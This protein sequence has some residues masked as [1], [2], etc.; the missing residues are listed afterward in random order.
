MRWLARPGSSRL[1]SV[2]LLVGC[3]AVAAASLLLDRALSYDAW[4]WLMWGREL[5]GHL[6]FSTN[7][8]PTWKPLTGLLAVPL[9][10]LGG[11]GPAL[12]LLIARFGAVLSLALAFRLGRR[13][14]GPGAGVLAAA[15]VLLMPDWVFQAGV[16]GSEPLLTALL[17][18]AVARHADRD[19]G[20]GFALVLLASLL[21]PESWG[22]LLASAVV[23]WRRMPAIRPLV[24]AG[25]VTVPLLWLG[26]DYLGSGDPFRGAVLAKMSAEAHQLR[27][28]GVPPAVEVLDRAWP[29]VL[30]PLLACIP[31]GLGY[32][33]RRRDPIL[34]TLALGGLGWVAE[35]AALA[36]L[37][38]AGV[39]RFLFPAAAALAVVGAA[40]FMLL[41]RSRAA[42]PALRLG[43]AVGLIALA[44]PSAASIQAARR[45]AT[46]A[47]ARAD[48]EQALDRLVARFGA[49]VLRAR[50]DLSFEGVDLTGFAWRIGV[51]PGSLRKL[52]LPGLR[53]ATRDPG[54]A[55]FW[56]A[57]H[58]RRRLFEAET[59]SH[60]GRVFVIAVEPRA[61]GSRE[62]EGT[63]VDQRRRCAEG[64]VERSH[65][66]SC[67]TIHAGATTD[68]RGGH[69]G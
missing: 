18:A 17:L 41:L 23:T 13:V 67:G 7:G 57:L 38:Y 1:R 9:A 30:L 68:G 63:P 48:L 47:E 64:S 46:R 25:L 44:V 45:E 8:Y 10:P 12:W 58:S 2:P 69:H 49:Q 62:D 3:L 59:L 24:I 52:R 32:G 28:S 53:V 43:G 50:P 26:G 22:P 51:L 15:S 31:V 42:T 37:G 33:L 5:V 56:R 16:G 21:R 66:T 61:D 14:A 11:A 27:Q 34:M 29:M 4:G 19:D 39:T 20:V 55:P 60:D 54:W 35:V 65:V 40:G 36:T 6:R